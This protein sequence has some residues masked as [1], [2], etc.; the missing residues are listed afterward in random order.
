[1]S[2]SPHLQ[3]IYG[4]NEAGK[5]TIMA[6]IRAI[7]FG[8]PTKQRQRNR[9]EPKQSSTYGGKVTLL[10]KQ[11][12]CVV[13]ERVKGRAN[14]EVSVYYEDGT[15]AGEE[16]LNL[17]L[18]G[19]DRS[20]FCG[21]FTFNLFDLQG[22]EQLDEKELATFLHGVSIGGQLSVSEVEKSIQKRQ[23]D[24]FKPQ[25]KNP[26]INKTIETLE[27]LSTEL[28]RKEALLDQYHQLVEQKMKEEKKL[29]SVTTSK[30][31]KQQKIRELEKL[32]VIAPIYTEIQQVTENIRN[33]PKNE[34]FPRDGLTRLEQLL[35][36]RQGLVENQIELEEKLEQVNVKLAS[37]PVDERVLVLQEDIHQFEQN[38]YSSEKIDV[39][40]ATRKNEI[41]ME[42]ENIRH[43][44]EVLGSRWTLE[45]VMN[46]NTSIE[47]KGSLKSLQA[48]ER[49][50]IER[51]YQLEKETE[52][53]A[54]VLAEKEQ[55]IE[56]IKAEISFFED[57]NQTKK[58]QKSKEQNVGQGLYVAVVSLFIGFALFSFFQ[59]Q[60]SLSVVALLIGVIVLVLGFLNKSFGAKSE[61]NVEF[62]EEN[63]SYIELKAKLNYMQLEFDTDTKGYE[64]LCNR[65]EDIEKDL[66]TLRTEVKG[67][68]EQFGYPLY[69]NVEPLETSISIVIEVKKCKLKIDR[70]VPELREIEEKLMKLLDKKEWIEQQM[71][72]GS[73]TLSQT[74]VRCKN[75]IENESEKK[76]NLQVL[77][78][79]QEELEKE[80]AITDSKLTMIEEE[81]NQLYQLAGVTNEET[82]RK[83]GL[84]M[85]ERE[86]LHIENKRLT[87]QLASIQPVESERNRLISMLV[88]S[89]NSITINELESEIEEIERQE[90]EVREAVIR[91]KQDIESLESGTSYSRLLQE[92]ELEK[93]KLQ[94]EARKWATF[95]AAETII[96]QTKA[97]Y[98]TEKQPEV[99][100]KTTE[101][102]ADL[103]DGK[104]L[105]VFA[106]VNQQQL[107]VERHDGIRF[108]PEELSR[109]TSE[110]LYVA[111]RL[112]LAESYNIQESFP[113]I[114]DDILV[115]FDDERRERLVQKMLE[116][117][118]ERQVLLFT[119]HLSVRDYFE[120]DRVLNLQ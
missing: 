77:T 78:T 79:L 18:S 23:S 40:I 51:Q 5:S 107:I 101:L 41:T 110:L 45:D 52:Q 63:R 46:C 29:E 68:C 81:L 98:E 39:D 119:C 35:L 59:E 95:K 117:S 11:N 54:I 86:Q 97:V 1:M 112:A 120:N 55:A 33:Y 12:G 48:T 20:I 73:G 84:E 114:M 85:A 42:Q 83:L 26:M 27:K 28:H 88:H 57:E 103:T 116:I 99:M 76:K 15:T 8:F 113:V 14:G 22:L 50:L 105:R 53:R 16:Q 82:F 38:V 31:E 74:V 66:V 3:V 2:L 91:S 115:N 104:Y 47:A 4:K 43:Q 49:R 37:S 87:A 89:Q 58:N 108:T 94:S 65:L 69:T 19:V 75:M 96:Q 70:L 71:G 30:R 72:L 106:P 21:V 67:W 7:L 80:K 100:K 56:R 10:T 111:I 32:A 102:F 24:L 109:G 64:R 13:I 93:S 60:L 34:T 62:L 90:K 118:K 36:R 61:K 17:I 25:G 44:M 9:Y 6:F 92:L